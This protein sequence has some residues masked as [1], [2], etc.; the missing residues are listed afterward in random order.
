MANST[1]N[2]NPAQQVAAQQQALA[3]ATQPTGESPYEDVNEVAALARRQG[4][5]VLVYPSMVR[6]DN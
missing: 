6:V 2:D 3:E 4:K 1:K 5:S